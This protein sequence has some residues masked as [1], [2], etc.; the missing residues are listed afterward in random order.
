MKT[1]EPENPGLNITTGVFSEIE[2]DGTERTYR[3]VLNDLAYDLVKDPCVTYILRDG[4]LTVRSTRKNIL[5]VF[6]RRT[7]MLK[8]C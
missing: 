8:Y 5:I 6:T 4:V 3:L 2:A 1:T 7:M